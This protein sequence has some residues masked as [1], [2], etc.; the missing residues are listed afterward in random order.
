MIDP[1]YQIAMDDWK[2]AGDIDLLPEPVRHYIAAHVLCN[3]VTNGSFFQY[4]RTAT[5]RTYTTCSRDFAHAVPP[6]RWSS[7]RT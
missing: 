5:A 6:P 1:L 4:S 2:E 7:P 3:E